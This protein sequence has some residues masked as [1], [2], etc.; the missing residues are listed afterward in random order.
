M[1]A[2]SPQE[3]PFSLLRKFILIAVFFT[4]TPLALFASVISLVAITNTKTPEVLGETTNIFE[5]PEKGVQVYAS[6][7]SEFPTISTK[8]III[9]I[10]AS[11]DY[12]QITNKIITTVKKQIT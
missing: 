7:P 6:L 12:F 2:E 3:N 10:V 9:F 5:Q 4:L 8:V 1:Q 11:K